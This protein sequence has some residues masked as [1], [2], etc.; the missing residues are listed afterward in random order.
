MEAVRWLL[1]QEA[2]VREQVPRGELVRIIAELVQASRACPPAERG[3]LLQLAL[4]FAD[5]LPPASAAGL[6]ASTLASDARAGELL[7]ALLRREP[8]NPD[9]LRLAADAA[10]RSGDAVRAHALL[11]RLGEADPRLTTLTHCARLRRQLPQQ[12]P[13]VKVALLSSY[14]I[15]QLV[16]FLEHE[17]AALGLRSQIYVTPFN[18]WAQE[19]LDPGSGLHEFS[20][21]IAFF[22]L[23]LDDLLPEL[24]GCPEPALLD[25]LGEE[26]VQRVA[27]TVQRYAQTSDALIVVHSFFSAYR[28]PFGIARPAT[29]SRVRWLARLNDRLAAALAPFERVRLLDVQEALLHRAGGGC[30]NPKLRHYAAM[31]LPEAALA[32]VAR[33]S[34]G[35]IAAHK[36]LT[37]KCV[38]LDLDN[39]LWGGVIGEDGMAG[40]R[41]GN[42]S[43]GSEYLEFQQFLHSLTERGILLAVNSKN[44]E[45]DAREVLREHEAML[46]REQ[47]FSA[48]YINWSPKPDNMRALAA[49][50][51]IGLDSLVFVDDNPNERELM[52]QALPEVLTPELPA[53]PA[54]YRRVLE[55]LP[56][57]Q[58][59]EVTEEDRERAQRY[60]A[61]RQRDQVR[62]SA[63]DLH[64]YLRSLHIEVRIAPAA[65]SSLPRIH[66]LFQRT[67]QFN[68]TTRRYTAEELRRFAQSEQARLYALW[69]SDRFGDHGLVATALVR[70]EGKSWRIDSLLMSCRVIGYGVETTLT[71]IIAREAAAAG[72]DSLL[73]EFIP[74]AKNAPAREFYRQHGFEPLEEQSDAPA[75]W[76][77]RLR[78]ATLDVPD[79]IALKEV[80]A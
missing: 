26:A 54:L 8:R 15:D 41:L 69:A 57:L 61:R 31:R 77:L 22:A 25:A 35:Y 38:V 65:E 74:T 51:N 20:P 29:A 63:T 68:L 42:T 56:Q 36:G 55:T 4:A 16:P 60:R 67:N 58:T 46:L 21:E 12:R 50:L 14:T 53:D 40:I 5:L 73:G 59:L 23:A 33:L 78:D 79:W 44:N 17:C 72:C 3:T 19:V 6:L 7:E 28:D 37:R 45:A 9:L 1:E 43:P 27:E 64:S 24:A 70:C 13:Q 47:A 32:E 10:V 39:T 18:S 80:Q 71:A 76:R 48:L 75:L 34:A 30:D 49:E 52:R 2:A 62:A 11:L 66:Q